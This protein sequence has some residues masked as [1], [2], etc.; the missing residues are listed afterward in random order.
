MRRPMTR[1][2]TAGFLLLLASAGWADGPTPA[3][4]PP[5][6]ASALAARMVIPPDATTETAA[7]PAKAAPSVAPAAVEAAV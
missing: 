2:M 6:A 4:P 5:A 3:A 7:K 1:W